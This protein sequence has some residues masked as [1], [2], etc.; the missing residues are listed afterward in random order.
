M[1]YDKEA[2]YDSE[3]APLVAQI[4]DV[5]KK[6]DLPLVLSVQYAAVD[7]VESYCS[8]TIPGS[9]PG[10]MMERLRA[11]MLAEVRR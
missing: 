2:V 3:I 9:E 11:V 4:L 7:G 1:S 5:C 10:L 6:H 8:T